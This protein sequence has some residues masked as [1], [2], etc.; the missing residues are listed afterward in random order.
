MAAALTLLQHCST[1]VLDV[2]AIPPICGL[3]RRSLPHSN[4]FRRVFWAQTGGENA[5]SDTE[6]S[7]MLQ[8]EQSAVN[9][10][11]SV[12]CAIWQA[13]LRRQMDAKTEPWR[14]RS[15]CSRSRL[16]DDDAVL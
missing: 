16:R 6:P 11:I 1:P 7:A 8:F 3:A 4:G 14:T 13:G 12:Y 5:P 2:A 10:W 15:F 9:G